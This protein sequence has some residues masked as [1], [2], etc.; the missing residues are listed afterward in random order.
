MLHLRNAATVSRSKWGWKLPCGRAEKG[1]RRRGL[2]V[3]SSRLPH[4]LLARAAKVR[5]P[6]TLPRD[7][8]GAACVERMQRT[9]E[10]SEHEVLQSPSCVEDAA[11]GS[12]AKLRC[13]VF[14]RGRRS[15][16]GRQRHGVPRWRPHLPPQRCQTDSSSQ[17]NTQISSIHLSVSV[18]CRS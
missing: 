12:L 5:L 8:A 7:F 14:T 18:G 4:S 2:N 10:R 3:R 15:A 9:A 6:P 13:G 11:S 16:S 17:L 1:W